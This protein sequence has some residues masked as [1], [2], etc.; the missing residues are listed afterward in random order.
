M[1]GAGPTDTH[2]ST[3]APTQ[4]C[5]VCAQVIVRRHYLTHLRQE[6]NRY[7]ICTEQISKA[8]QFIRANYGYKVLE[9]IC[10]RHILHPFRHRPSALL[11]AWLY[12]GL[13][14][15]PNTGW[16]NYLTLPSAVKDS[17]AMIFP[18]G[19]WSQI[20]LARMK[21]IRGTDAD[22][23]SAPGKTERWRS[24]RQPQQGRSSSRSGLL[25][26]VCM[27]CFVI[28][29]NWPSLHPTLPYQGMARGG[30]RPWWWM[31]RF[32]KSEL[33]NSGAMTNIGAVHNCKC[34][35]CNRCPRWNNNKYSPVNLLAR[36][37]LT[38]QRGT[39]S[40]KR[41]WWLSF[42]SDCVS[43]CCVKCLLVLAVWFFFCVCGCTYIFVCVWARGVC[44]SVLSVVVWF[45]YGQCLWNPLPQHQKWKS[46]PLW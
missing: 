28:P 23:R 43:L 14:V 1:R 31:V 34:K 26:S 33:H 16:S 10:T 8:V 35:Q 36:L 27:S 12:K 40:V 17:C 25:G 41:A 44:S 42:S 7:S 15:Q 37:P 38:S 39:G 18:Q 46:N 21:S 13:T 29:S 5:P 4:R 30:N 2:R 20:S 45:N 6:N 11:P 19:H 3:R 9:V 32:G 24:R 22:N